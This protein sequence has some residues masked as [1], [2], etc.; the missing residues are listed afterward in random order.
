M[1]QMEP[2]INKHLY[3]IRTVEAFYSFDELIFIM[4][5]KT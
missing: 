3:L 1:V 4:N 5:Y 2:K